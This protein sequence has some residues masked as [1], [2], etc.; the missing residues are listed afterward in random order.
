MYC[1]KVLAGYSFWADV[2]PCSCMIFKVWF[3]IYA[4]LNSLITSVLFSLLLM[5]I[6]FVKE[7]ALVLMIWLAIYCIDQHMHLLHMK[8]RF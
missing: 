1:K 7:I 5:E 8:R 3:S 4:W 2:P 6:H